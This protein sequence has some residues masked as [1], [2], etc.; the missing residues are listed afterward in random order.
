MA[1][2]TKMDKKVESLKIIKT[3]YIIYTFIDYYGNITKIKKIFK[4]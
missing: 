3:Y 1:N 2:L 4:K